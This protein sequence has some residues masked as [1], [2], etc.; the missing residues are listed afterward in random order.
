MKPDMSDHALVV[1]DA[2]E[3]DENTSG[4]S[5]KNISANRSK[6]F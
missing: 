3:E 2:V 6:N 4:A 5:T 1:V